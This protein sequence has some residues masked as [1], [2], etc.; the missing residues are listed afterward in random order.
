[1]KDMIKRAKEYGNELIYD[2]SGMEFLEVAIIIALV[3]GLIGVIAYLF[4][5]IGNKVSDAG[6]SVDTMESTPSQQTNPWNSGS[7]GP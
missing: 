4:T 7:S 6:E 2:E 3:V 5:M 1:M